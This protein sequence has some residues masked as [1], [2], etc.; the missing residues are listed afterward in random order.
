MQRNFAKY[1][2][3]L[4]DKIEEVQT[5]TR[6]TNFEMKNL[7]KKNNETEEDLMDIVLSLSN[8]IYCK[9]KKSDIRD[10]YRIRSLVI[11]EQKENDV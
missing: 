4:E 7:P 9:I 2:T 8:K 5:D 3:I 6:K 11:S 1:I 10:M